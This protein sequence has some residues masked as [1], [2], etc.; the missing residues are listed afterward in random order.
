MEY[1]ALISELRFA[2]SYNSVW[3]SLA[4]TMELFVRKT[5]LTLYNRDWP[6]MAASSP[7]SSRSLINQ[8]AFRALV[9][10]KSSQ[11][12]LSEVIEKI[13]NVD[14][15]RLI[16][17]HFTGI[18]ILSDLELLEAGELASRMGRRL[19][20]GG[21]ANI[22]LNPRFEGCGFIN[23]CFGDAV[24]AQGGIWELK[25]GDRP[26]RSYEFRQVSIYGALYLDSTGHAPPFV[27]VINSRRGVSVQVTLDTLANEVAGQSGIDYLR[28]VVRA[29]S[30][31]TANSGAR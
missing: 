19:L 31:E 28:E 30:D 22:T 23:A 25:D 5:N 10:A 17:T 4:P 14:N 6:E 9:E 16:E 13:Q 2:K 7:A 29:I 11:R 8:V 24:T 3:R 1:S 21:M 15:L 20:S 12:Y 18:S 26:F 27:G